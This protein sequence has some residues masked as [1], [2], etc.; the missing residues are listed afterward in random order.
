MYTRGFPLPVG[1]HGQLMRNWPIDK[2]FPALF[3]LLALAL[4]VVWL[5]ARP[6]TPVA[7]RVPGTDR[8]GQT[9]APPPPTAPLRATLTTGAGVAADLTGSWPCFR[10]AERDGVARQPQALADSWPDA[11]PTV[12]WS[13]EVGEGYAG[14]VIQRGRVYL[15][16]YDRPNQA[17]ALRCLSLTDGREIWRST[18]PVKIKRYHG[19][20]RTV[21]AVT[22][23]HVVSMGPKCHVLCVDAVTGEVRWL[24]DLVRD[25][26][27]TVPEWY[28]GQCP[29]IDQGRAI[30][31]PGGPKELLMAVDC[32][33]GEIIWRTPNPRNWQMTHTSI[34]PMTLDGRKTYVYCGSRG[35]VAVDADDG[36][37]IWQTEEWQV[38]I[39]TVPSPVVVPGNRI[40]LTGGYQAGSMM[41]QIAASADGYTAQPLF[42]LKDKVF[43]AD[44][45]TPILFDGLIYGIRPGGELTCLDLDGKVR[46]TS[47]AATRFGLG[48]LLIADGR[49]FAMDDHGS[50]TLAKVDPDSYQPLATAS[51]VPGHESW[52][53]LALADGRL[54]VRNLKQMVCLD[55]SAG[56]RR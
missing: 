7:L 2:L 36:S 10:G 52:A 18:Y 17:D 19:M 48:P 26:G 1:Y 30:I 3:A 50:L 6:G 4:L 23:R 38:K 27:T 5:S 21:P 43:G 24:L 45:Q 20:S 40:L 13:S 22:E 46:W 25:F 41:L 16:D 53:P 55:V 35:V 12:L 39:A 56:K 54:I 15:M 11:G 49:I 29:L 14:A 28:A 9:T 32:A 51:V 8:Q 47:G 31:A 34:T 33:S 37:I 44:M 42:R